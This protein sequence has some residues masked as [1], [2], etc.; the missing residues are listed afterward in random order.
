MPTHLCWSFGCFV[1][2][3]RVIDG[4][5]AAHSHFFLNKQQ[6]VFFQV[7]FLVNL[8]ILEDS[9]IA[10]ILF[11]IKVSKIVNTIQYLFNSTNSY[12]LI[13]IFCFTFFHHRESHF[14]TKTFSS[15][16]VKTL[17]CKPFVIWRQTSFN[18]MKESSM[19]F[20]NLYI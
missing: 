20:L 11:V 9:P 4:L 1:F 12:D 18:R 6:W 14:T 16:F 2:C 10:Y 19:A 5:V 3:L 8:E 15:I 7:K 17:R 13:I